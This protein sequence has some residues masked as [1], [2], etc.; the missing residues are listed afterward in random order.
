MLAKDFADFEKFVG[1][2]NILFL[3]NPFEL[4]FYKSI[5]DNFKKYKENTF[6]SEKQGKI[7]E[8]IMIKVSNYIMNEYK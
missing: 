6:I 5:K 1:D 3:L 7:L 4:K 2:K 8:K